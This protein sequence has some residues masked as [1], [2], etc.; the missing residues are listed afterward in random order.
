M[1]LETLVL[2]DVRGFRTNGSQIR[3][4]FVRPDG[5]YEGLTVVAG[6]NGSGKST[7][8][9]SIALALSGPT[10]ARTL[11]PGYTGWISDGAEIAKV[12][13]A[14]SQHSEDAFGTGGAPPKSR[15]W[16]GLQWAED[17]P[18]S[19]AELSESI[20]KS[21]AKLTARRGP[22]LE[23]PTGWFIAGYGPF[24]RLNGAAAEAQ[25]SMLGSK[26]TA[27]LVTLFDESASL[28][29][30]TWWL[31]DIY[32]RSLEGD[33]AAEQLIDDIILVLNDGLLPDGTTVTRYSSAGLWVRQA[34]VEVVLDDMSDGYRVVASLVIDILRRMYASFGRLAVER[35]NDGSVICKHRGIVLIDEIDVHLH[36][37][38]QQRIGFWLRDHFPNIQFIVSTHSPFVAQAASPNGLLKLPAPNDE[39]R[40]PTFVPEPQFSAVVNGDIDRV[41]MS[42]LFGLESTYS[43]ET[44]RRRELWQAMEADQFGEVPNDALRQLRDELAVGPSDDV[45]RALRHLDRTLRA[46]SA[47]SD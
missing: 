3:L 42:Q 31:Q 33:K 13:A 35:Q 22:W 6:R 28:A 32:P 17:E 11:M 43:E 36:V 14:F 20:P 47:S 45:A 12:Q 27:A 4:D 44:L 40:A 8:L 46:T 37:G 25:R 16:A 38:W 2:E 39:D 5:S 15:P 7:L 19:F 23:N 21:S 41:S 29:E 26:R 18:G 30:S 1:Y 10:T 9:R 34:G 24:R